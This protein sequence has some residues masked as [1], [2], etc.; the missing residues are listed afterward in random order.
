MPFRGEFRQ[1]V[2]IAVPVV[3]VQVGM[4][5]MGVVDTLMVGHV[6]ASA[7][8]A[9]AL[10]NLYFYNVIVVAMGTVMALD[11]IVSQA[12]GA[13]D[14]VAVTRG[15]QRGVILA[16]V[17]GV[18][19]MLLMLT[20]GPV[21]TAFGQPAG[22]VPDATAFAHISAL[23]VIPFLLFIVFRQVL[24]AVARLTPVVWTIIGANALNAGLNWVFI[25]GHLGS[26]PLGVRGSA[27][28]TV[29]SRL[30]MALMLLALSWPHLRRYLMHFD[31]ASFDLAPLGRMLALGLPIG[32]Q[33]FL[34]ISAFG[35]IGLLTGKFGAEQVAAYQIALNMAAL[36]FMVPLGVSAAAS[37]RVGNAVGA[38]DAPRSR[39]AARQAYLL[40]IG[41]MSTTAILFLTLPEQ[42]AG[43]YTRDATVI[44]IAGLLVPIAGVFQIFDGMQAVGAGVLR[45]LGDTRVPLVAMLTGYWLIGV[46][47][48]VW[49]GFYTNLGSV[50]L[51]WGFVAGLA[52]VALFLLIRVRVMFARGVRRVVIDTGA[53]A[54]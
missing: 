22:V 6:S 53:T 18:P 19:T 27:I 2:T 49:L 31:R 50:G 7:L 29:A 11:P 54:D 17:M 43:L 21:F 33:Q 12:V 39:V 42:L 47:V 52:S 13:N 38:G 9:A 51:W 10:G 28:A 4:M 14:E 46:P 36:T 8:A 30:S 16:V 40:G 23:G 48:S 26:P 3:I 32:F 41:F 25:Y 37:V 24:Q 45:G 44:A 1:L 34:E 20:A 35:T 5:F 15:V